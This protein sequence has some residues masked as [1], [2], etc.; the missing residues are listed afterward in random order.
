LSS[1][2][3]RRMAFT[4]NRD[5]FGAMVAVCMYWIDWMD[6]CSS[7]AGMRIRRVL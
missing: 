4:L 7:P 5:M 3:R 2:A 1:A 6:V